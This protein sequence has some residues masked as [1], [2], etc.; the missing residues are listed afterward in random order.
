MNISPVCVLCAL[1]IASAGAQAQIVVVGATSASAAMSREQVA[2]AFMGK[3]SG[4]E[5]LDQAERAPI[6][7]EFYSKI[8]GKSASQ[9]KS[10]WAKIS[11]TGRGTP[12]KEY[13]NSTEIK[14]ALSGNPNAIGYVEKSAVDSAVRIVFEGR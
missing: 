2:D 14:K 11:F 3:M 1:G 4:V 9:V 7:E 12:P 8:I 5:P 10:Y 13:S 6:R